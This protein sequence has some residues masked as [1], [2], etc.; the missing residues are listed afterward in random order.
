[1]T[2]LLWVYTFQLLK[3]GVVKLLFS[4]LP[5]LNPVCSC[6]YNFPVLQFGFFTARL[7][8]CTLYL[9]FPSLQLPC[10]FY[11]VSLIF[12]IQKCYSH[13]EVTMHLLTVLT[14]TALSGASVRCVILAIFT[15][16]NFNHHGNTHLFDLIHSLIQSIHVVEYLSLLYGIGGFYLF[17][18]IRRNN[19]YNLN[20]IYKKSCS[21]LLCNCGC[22]CLSFI[23]IFG[24]GSLIFVL[25][26]FVPTALLAM[27]E[28]D[29]V[30]A[31]ITS[32]DHLSRQDLSKL[33]VGISY[34]SH[35]CHTA[36]RFFIVYVTIVIRSAWLDQNGTQH[37]PS[38]HNGLEAW[39]IT[40]LRPQW[41]EQEIESG[42]DK[43]R[44]EK[45]ASLIDNY[46]R[47]GQLVTPLQ[48]IFQQW[49]VMQWVV[50]FI[51][52]IEDFSV[53]LHSL[54][55]EE[56]KDSSHKH[57]LLFVITHL[58]FD[59]ILFIVPYFCASLFNQYHEEYRER[60]KQEQ[61]QIFSEQA[62]SN[63]WMMQCAELIPENPK[64]AFV[65]SFCGLSIP[66]SSPGYNISIIFA[67]FAFIISVMTAL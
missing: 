7:V 8:L 52:I 50:Y 27:W 19:F 1:M 47:I 4:I 5:D 60:L 34:L 29:I 32:A 67:L 6:H 12:I 36:T 40:M 64:Y 61:I 65:P 62:E 11:A 53:V 33:Y 16:V 45:F 26:A 35:F 58:V 63:G 21:R 13:C 66:L 39:A 18:L 2:N 14:V 49:F 41:L 10:L 57:K 23:S 42:G 25:S 3:I 55:T 37:Q 46:N 44:K 59:L 43:N 30:T 17:T 28:T 48:S 22:M 24:F 31:N 15:A 38:M 20:N 51:K 54:V 9:Q 56:F